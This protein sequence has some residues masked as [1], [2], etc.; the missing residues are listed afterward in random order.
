MRKPDSSLVSGLLGSLLQRQV[1][2]WRL[3]SF[4]GSLP[5][6]SFSGLLFQKVASKG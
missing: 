3:F 4:R 1:M 6:P 2:L 5:D